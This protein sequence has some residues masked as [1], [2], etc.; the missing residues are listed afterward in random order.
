MTRETRQKEKER[1][2]GAFS[3][4]DLREARE[5]IHYEGNALLRILSYGKPYWVTLLVCLVMVLAASALEIYRPQLIK[6]AIDQ[7]IDG[8]F[9]AGERV[10]ERF[11]GLLGIGG[12]YLAIL[13]A[14]LFLSRVQI[15]LMQRTGQEI[16]EGMRNDI[17]AHV[18]SL[19]MRF[20]DITPV[21]K[22][23]TRLTNDVESI[24]EVFTDILVNLIRNIVM[25]IGLVV[26]M[27]AMN[28]RMALISLITVP[29]VIG[30]TWL[31]RKL[32]REAYQITRTRVTDLNTFLSE[33]ISGMHLIQCFGQ[34]EKKKAEFGERNDSLYRAGFRELM[35]HAIF[36]PLIYMIS[37]VAMVL[38]M[39]RGS[40]AVLA[41][42]VSFGTLYVFIDYIDRLFQPIQQLTEQFSTL[43]NAIAS[44]EKIFTLMDTKP[45][46]AEPE[47]P[48]CP[49]KILG[50]IEFDHVWFAY[51]GEEWVL[52]DV[53]FTIEP[54]QRVAFV[55][56]TGAG[57]SSILN[58]IGRYYDVQRGRIL[59]DGTDVRQMSRERLRAAIGQVQQDVFLFTGDVAGNIR[60][61]DT[62][63]T[64]EQ[65]EAAARE[66]NAAR[67]IDQLPAGYHHPVSERGSTFS[68]GQRQLISFAR[69]LAHNPAILVLDEATANID[70]ETE[71]WIQEATE[72]LMQ[73][74]TTIVVAHRLST[75]Q[76]ADRIMVIHHGRLM[77]SGTHQELLALDGIY[78][79]LYQLQLAGQTA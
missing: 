77:E 40:D 11:R 76:H 43:Q 34:E 64:D 50:R 35:V 4:Q 25:I 31:Y 9:G 56:A 63:I 2:Q 53:S 75:I 15:W 30:V 16:I 67:F 29:V 47:H 33:H 45:L 59:V 70:T 5:D 1:R 26:V 79:K 13:V 72:R 71:Q 41:D 52:K 32:C 36:R 12:I 78:R 24:N 38:L 22:I 10:E 19:T 28:A 42:T 69:T 21:G 58:L 23:V 48:V 17:F 37:V 27:F 18:E 68:A 46:L 66:V 39:G 3:A 54:G 20:F 65:V 14:G 61:T 44:A 57:K 49:E 8:G 74:R 6:Q 55:G 62:D 7:F 73:G 60:L 51:Q